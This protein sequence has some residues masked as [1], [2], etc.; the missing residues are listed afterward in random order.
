M[1]SILEQI[2]KELNVPSFSL[3]AKDTGEQLNISVFNGRISLT[4]FPPKGSN[5]RGVVYKNSLNL[6]GQQILTSMISNALSM[7]PG[8]KKTLIFQDFVERAFVPSATFSL[9]KDDKQVY[10]FE[11]QFKYNDNNKTI[12]FPLIAGESVKESSAESSFAD[13]SKMRLTAIKYWLDC[14]V[15]VACVL[16]GRKFKPNKQSTSSES[17]GEAY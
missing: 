12:V 15:P 9:I 16:T 4:V 3:K 1:D 2:Q 5:A 7:S 6:E 13:R 14:I 11:L 10:Q 8:S 17:D